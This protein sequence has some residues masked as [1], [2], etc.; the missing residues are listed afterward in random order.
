MNDEQLRRKS[1][2]AVA[3]KTWAYGDDGLFRIFDAVRGTYLREIAESTPS[4]SAFRE[5]A[6]QRIQAL[7]DL[8]RAMEAVIA[9]GSGADH[10]LAALTKTADR[11][12]KRKPKVT[13]YA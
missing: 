9:D 5:T 2:R 4:E 1:A 13:P 10:M 6:Y 11:K 12:T 3:L 8:R 7:A